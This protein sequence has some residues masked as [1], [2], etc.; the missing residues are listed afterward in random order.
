[1]DPSEARLTRIENADGSYEE[2]GPVKHEVAPSAR[3]DTTITTVD[4]AETCW[5]PPPRW[6]MRQDPNGE[7]FRLCSVPYWLLAGGYVGVWFGG[8]AAWQRRKAR[9]LTIAPPP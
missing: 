4:P 9:L 6:Q 3:G 2:F 7:D 1:M 5:F 8:L